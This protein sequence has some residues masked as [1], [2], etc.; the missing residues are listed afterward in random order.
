MDHRLQR[1]AILCDVPLLRRGIQ[2]ALSAAADLQL[3]IF[4]SKG[5]ETALKRKSESAL[6]DIVILVPSTFDVIHEGISYLHHR[7]CRVIVLSS[8]AIQC[9]AM[10]AI[11]AGARGYL[12]HDV[13]ESELLTAIRTVACNRTYI[14]ANLTQLLGVNASIT[15]RERQI[16]ELLA[17]GHTDREIARKLQISEHTVHS[18]LDRLRAKTGLRRRAD[19]TRLAL[20]HGMPK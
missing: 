11:H 7:G 1:V 12:D 13:E 20:K 2:H 18:H 14:S 16:L 10:T 8:S 9:D 19:L 4:S 6:P 15:E 5:G 17:A 3:E